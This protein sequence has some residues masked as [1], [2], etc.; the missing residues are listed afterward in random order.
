M[1][2]FTGRIKAH[3]GYHIY[4]GRQSAIHMPRTRHMLGKDIKGPHTY[5]WQTY[6]LHVMGIDS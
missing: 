6:G 2:R 4:E 1:R 5:T 3:K